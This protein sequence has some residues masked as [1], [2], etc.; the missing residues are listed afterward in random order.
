MSPQSN[1]FEKA[2]DVRVSIFRASSNFEVPQSK[3]CVECFTSAMSN[4]ND[5]HIIPPHIAGHLF[6]RTIS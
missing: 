1:G 2:R 6:V 4:A 3:M 5:I